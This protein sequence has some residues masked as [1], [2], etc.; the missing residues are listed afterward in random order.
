MTW[1]R[2]WCRGV[3]MA[4]L[5][6]KELDEAGLL[7]LLQSQPTYYGWLGCCSECCRV[8]STHSGPTIDHL[9]GLL[10]QFSLSFEPSMTFSSYLS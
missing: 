8:F 7:P 4:R 1:S 9:M 5:G 3:E 10:L 2:K 6:I